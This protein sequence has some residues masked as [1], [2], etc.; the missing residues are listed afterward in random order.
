MNKQLSAAASHELVGP[1]VAEAEAAAIRFSPERIAMYQRLVDQGQLRPKTAALALLPS[2]A[3]CGLYLLVLWL[4]VGPQ[5]APAQSAGLF[6]LRFPPGWAQLAPWDPA[7][8][9]PGTLPSRF[10][11]TELFPGKPV[12]DQQQCGSCWA[13]GTVGAVEYQVFL[14]DR[15]DVDLSEQW[16]VSCNRDGSSC[17]GG[18][19]SFSYFLNSGPFSDS[20]G[21]RGAVMENDFP[22]TADNGTCRCPY[23]H[24]YTLAGWSYIGIVPGVLATTDQI[25]RAVHLFGPIAVSVYAGNWSG[26]GAFTHVLQ[27][28][29]TDLPNHMVVIVGWDDSR[30]AWRI[31]NSWGTGWGD[32]GEAWVA[33]GCNSIGFGASYV[34]Y[35]A[36]RGNWVDFGHTGPETGLFN[37]PFNTISEG[38][39]T[40]N[41]HGTLSI[42]AGVSPGPVTLTSP[43]TIKSFGGPVTIGRR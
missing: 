30:G 32:H 40:L 31:R 15:K 11:W 2:A 17:D 36:G 21:G 27:N 26:L 28:C 42:K 23:A 39:N 19:V 9:L 13:F 35:P 4:T 16:L 41:A 29:A 20:C 3:R 10:V 22:Y 24:S 18:F 38:T 25:K 12:R 1:G 7:I 34:R 6:G 43:M 33:Y 37:Q 8:P 5:A 14:Y